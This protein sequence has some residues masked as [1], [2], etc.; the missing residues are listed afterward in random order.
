[1]NVEPEMLDYTG[2]NWSQWNSSRGLKQKFG[3]Y[4]RNTFSVD[5]LQETT[6]LGTS[7]IIQKVLQCRLTLHISQIVNTEQQ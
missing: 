6:I 7:H 2:N 5:S 3:C 4:T 1:M